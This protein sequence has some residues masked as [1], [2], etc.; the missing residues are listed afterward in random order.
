M[1]KKTLNFGMIGYKFMGGAHSQ[2][3]RRVGMHFD[4]DADVRMKAICGR[5]EE[6]VKKAAQQYGWEETETD[7]RTL[8]RR[9]DIDCVDVTATSFL[10]KEMCIAAA[11]AGKHILC[12]KPL[13]TTLG[14]A[15]AIVAAVEKAGVRHQVGFN[16]RFCPAVV[17]IKNMIDQGRLGKIFH[18]RGFYLQDYI[19]DPDFPKVWRLD[20]SIAGSGSHG[21]LN[22]HV[23]DLAR[24]LTGEIDQ[25]IGMSE[26]FIQE[27]PIVER[28]EGLSGKARGDAPRGKVDVD[29]AT[30][31]LAKF[32][33]GALGSFEATRFAQGHKNDMYFEINGEK[34]S[35]K[36]VFERMNEIQYFDSGADSGVQGWSTIQVSEGVHPYWPHWWPAGH[37]IGYDETFVHEM[38]EFIQNVANDRPCS[39]DFYDG[40]KCAQILEAVDQSIEKRAWVRVGD[41]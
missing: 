18:F 25:V 24:Y 7:Y 34:G 30:L 17:L 15:R 5:D 37:V 20:K 1:A 21:D 6:W 35:V 10:H 29:D 22:A 13:A 40:L 19:I 41:V 11:E 3:L 31:F 2:A 39:P 32:A 28:M 26:T 12:E 36:F 4:L 33:S 9:S 23:I 8:V 27:R 14:D 16:Y 38:Y